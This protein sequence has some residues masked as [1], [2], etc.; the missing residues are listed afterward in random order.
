MYWPNWLPEE[1]AGRLLSSIPRA[2]DG[3]YL[4]SVANTYPHKNMHALVEA[5]GRLLADREAERA[6]YADLLERAE[7]HGVLVVNKPAALRDVSEKAYTMWFPDCCPP[8]LITRTMAEMRRFLSDHGTIVVKPLDGMGGRSVFTIRPGDRNLNV[9][10]ETLT[11][12]GQR[13]AMAQTFIPEIT[14]GDKRV[15]MVDGRPVGHMLARVPSDE[16]G[17][18][19][20]VMG[21]TGKGQPLSDRDREICATVGPVLRDNGVIFAGIDVQQVLPTATHDEIRREVELG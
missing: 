11:D 16:D 8:T 2:A 19:N 7:E 13:F 9:V 12:F 18:G 20:L 14:D 4:L 21:A 10:I 17:R 3:P 5:F 6:N 15:L 1:D